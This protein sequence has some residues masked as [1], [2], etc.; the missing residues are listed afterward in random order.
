MKIKDLSM[1]EIIIILAIFALFGAMINQL[2][3][4]EKTTLLKSEWKCVK[5]EK[6]TTTQMV[7]KIMM[8]V[9][10]DVCVNYVKQ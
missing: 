8:P 9:T 1:I 10:R 3:F 6:R 2:F 7:G 4:E 5:Y